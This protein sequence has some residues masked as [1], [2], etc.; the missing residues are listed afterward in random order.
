MKKLVTVF[1]LCAAVSA[2]AQVES[3]NIVGYNSKTLEDG[4]NMTALQFK[5]VG[6]T[7][8]TLGLLFSGAMVD[9]AVTTPS[10]QLG[11][12]IADGDEVQFWDNETGGF[13]QAFFTDEATTGDPMDADPET[14]MAGWYDINGIDGWMNSRPVDLG[15]AFWF[16]RPI[17]GTTVKLTLAGEILTTSTMTWNCNAGFNMVGLKTPVSTKLNDIDWS[18]SGALIGTG[19]ADGDEIQF[20]DNSTGGFIQA[21]FTDEDT[22]GDP[23]DADSE[24][25]LTGWYDI[26]GT[27]WLDYTIQAGQGFWFVRPSAGD[28]VLP[29]GF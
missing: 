10:L 22:T 6:S 2:Y 12:G 4:F 7:G 5:A 25:N 16:V 9:A 1:A 19:I 21:F 3:A 15:R 14:N 17:G 26:N 20:W 24:T 29:R 11:T 27:G 18:A 8:S 28:I 23:I 13:V